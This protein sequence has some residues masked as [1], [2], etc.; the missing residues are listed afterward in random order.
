MRLN[1]PPKKPAGEILQQAV[2][3]FLGSIQGLICLSLA[4]EDLFFCFQQL[5]TLLASHLE[6]QLVLLREQSNKFF[7]DV[8]LVELP[9]LCGGSR[10]APY[11][12]CERKP[13]KNGL[14]NTYAEPT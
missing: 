6:H 2:S 11:C 5:D 9:L 12:L 1:P 7:A 10:F 4:L 8:L 13:Y 14:K 3:I